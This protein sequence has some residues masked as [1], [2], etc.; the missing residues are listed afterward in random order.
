MHSTL[1]LSPSMCSKFNAHCT[2]H[3]TFA[4]YFPT[5]CPWSRSLPNVL[6]L[7]EETHFHSVFPFGF[8]YMCFVRQCQ[9]DILIPRSLWFCSLYSVSFLL[10]LSW[11]TAPAASRETCAA[12]GTTPL[13]KHLHI[14]RWWC[15]LSRHSLQPTNLHPDYPDSTHPQRIK[16]GMCSRK[17]ELNREVKA[18]AI[19][20]QSKI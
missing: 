1:L 16:K 5:V 4:L 11:S 18:R 15:A 3:E 14:R 10:H 12:R 13:S 17:D 9:E 6:L 20:Q 7:Q 2:C 19:G 8:V